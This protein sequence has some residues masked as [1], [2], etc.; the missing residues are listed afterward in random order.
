VLPLIKY[1]LSYFKAL[2]TNY[3]KDD[4]KLLMSN[5]SEG[6]LT[7]K[8]CKHFKTATNNTWKKL[9]KYY[10]K[11]NDSPAYIASVVLNLSQR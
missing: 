6:I 1:I 7:I 8:S 2:K 3:D 10:A 11:L 9:D 5:L 4:N